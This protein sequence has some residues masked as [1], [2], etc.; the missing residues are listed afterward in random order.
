MGDGQCHPP[1]LLEVA[2]ALGG[3]ETQEGPLGV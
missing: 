3:E 2:E 1:L